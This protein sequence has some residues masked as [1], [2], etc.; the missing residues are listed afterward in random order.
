MKMYPV[1]TAEFAFEPPRIRRPTT[2]ESRKDLRPQPHPYKHVVY[3]WWWEY[4]KRHT[5]YLQTCVDGGGEFESLYQD[6][7]DVR[8]DDFWEWWTS[9]APTDDGRM[10][11]G[12]SFWAS[13]G[14]REDRSAINLWRGLYLFAEP[15]RPHPLVVKLEQPPDAA[16]F[17]DPDV[18]VL[19]VP[20]D[21]PDGEIYQRLEFFVRQ[22]REKRDEPEF[23]E[24]LE[25][26][27][28]LEIR[29]ESD[30]VDKIAALDQ[31]HTGERR[32]SRV[33]NQSQARY[34]VTSTPKIDFLKT[35]LSVYDYRQVSDL[36]LW[37]IG[38]ELNLI[39]PDDP[40]NISPDEKNTSAATVSRYLKKAK[41]MIKNAGYG[42]FPDVTPPS[43]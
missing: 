40:K 13:N 8:G 7:G 10:D 6:F 22:A 39:S 36:P 26:I 9:Q 35:A 23:I 29:D 28:K 20:I 4:L 21:L 19:K 37:K 42:R 17:S 16:L 33:A 3:Y 11:R 15:V 18:V 2:A 31:S 34:P 43:S 5:G 12:L 41:A 32:G 38:V 14:R 30:L 24:A 1:S 27:D 25:A